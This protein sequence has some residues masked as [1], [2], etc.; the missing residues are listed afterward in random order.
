MVALKC[1]VWWIDVPS[2]GAAGPL[3]LCPGSIPARAGRH[4]KT[5]QLHCHCISDDSVCL[6]SI[7]ARV[8]RQRTRTEVEWNGVWERA[9]W[10]PCLSTGLLSSTLTTQLLP[11]TETT[12][13][14]LSFPFC[15]SSNRDPLGTF[16]SRVRFKR[17]RFDLRGWEVRG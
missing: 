15:N 12:P 11:G 4:C 5:I 16:N 17:F 9:S 6:G 13:T 1:R 7:P 14:F 10:K 3:M 2:S 8:R